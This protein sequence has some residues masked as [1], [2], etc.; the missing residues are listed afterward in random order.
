MV[1]GVAA[2]R[3]HQGHVQLWGRGGGSRSCRLALSGLRPRI[4]R[5]KGYQARGRENP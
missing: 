1:L 5:R 4:T 2:R 3:P